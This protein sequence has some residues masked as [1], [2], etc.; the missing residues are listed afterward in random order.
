VDTLSLPPIGLQHPCIRQVRHIVTGAGP[1]RHRLFVA[2]GLSAHEVLLDLDA[3]IELF[4]WCPESG[5][6][7]QARTVS[8]RIAQRAAAAFRISQRVLERICERERPD[9]MLSLVP[10]PSWQPDQIRLGPDALV[11]VADSIE[12]PGNLGTL[13]RTV[14]ACGGDCVILTNRRTRLSHP[15]V[16]RGS[17]GM[18]LRIPVIEFAGPAEAAGWLRRN[19]FTTY[20]ATVRPDAVPYHRVSFNRRA[21]IVVGNE[22]HG[23]GA[24]WLETGFPQVTIP[25]YGRADSL[26]VAVSASILL[27]AARAGA[28]AQ[29]CARADTAGMPVTAAQPAR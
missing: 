24:Q 12:I 1:G 10:L 21:A 14:D 2:E 6:S 16:F 15:K 18:N 13:L 7:D 3:P 27:Y 23:I 4:L 19:G 8:T 11:L 22:R 20:L 26:N 28:A 29:R 25:M 9:G 5:Y 17:R